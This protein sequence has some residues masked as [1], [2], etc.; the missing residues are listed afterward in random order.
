MYIRL[1]SLPMALSVGTTAHV[2]LPLPRSRY[3]LPPRYC[4]VLVLPIP[5]SFSSLLWN[6][7]RPLTVLIRLIR[8]IHSKTFPPMSSSRNKKII[9]WLPVCAVQP[10][11]GY[12]TLLCRIG[13]GGGPSWWRHRSSGR[14]EWSRSSYRWKDLDNV[15]KAELDA[16]LERTRRRLD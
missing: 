14:C 4:W 6:Y 1:V 7:P 2:V 15:D 5:Q 3:P 16:A 11:Y 12:K 13:C 10:E 8:L 9:P